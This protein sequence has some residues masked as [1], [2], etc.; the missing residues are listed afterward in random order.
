ML[1]NGTFNDYCSTGVRYV[2][3]EGLEIVDPK[4]MTP[5]PADGTTLGEI[6]MRGNLVMKGYLKNPEANEEAFAN[7]WYPETAVLS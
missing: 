2:G 7:G 4:T 5:V 3:L 1:Q 6:V